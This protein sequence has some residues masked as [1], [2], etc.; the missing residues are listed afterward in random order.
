MRVYSV[1]LVIL[2]SLLLGGCGEREAPVSNDRLLEAF[3]DLRTGFWVSGEAPVS[4]LLGDEQI[5]GAHQRFVVRPNEEIAVTI[6]H[7]LSESARVP[8]ERGDVV[9]F[10][11]RYDWEARGGIVSLTHSDPDQPGGGGWIEHKGKRYD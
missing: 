11:G 2:T 4:Q 8:V 3:K 6:Y 9:R 5:G 10:R 7:S 1:L